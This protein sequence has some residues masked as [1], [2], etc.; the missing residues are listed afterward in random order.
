VLALGDKDNIVRF[1]KSKESP[2]G[3]VALVGIET[4]NSRMENVDISGGSGGYHDG[5]YFTGMFS[6]YDTDNIRLSNI[7]ISNNYKYD[8]LI[9]VLYSNKVDFT[10]CIV[11]NAVSDALDV[12]I[13]SVTINNCNFI[14]SGNDSIDSMTSTVKISETN[15]KNSGDKGVSAGERSHVFISKV[16]INESEIAI[17]SKDDSLVEVTNSSFLNNKVQLNAYRKNWRYGGGGRINVENSSFSGVDN[18]IT[19]KG[20]SK[21]NIVN[22]E[23]NQKYLH[24]KNKKVT[25]IN[26]RLTTE[27]F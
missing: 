17:Q 1:V 25:F 10:D 9:H 23:F 21:I 12:D 24:M 13:S 6:I 26:N 27:K 8:D 2:W 19:A 14:N 18:V 7:H 16:N 22:S 20:K 11:S 5:L 15:I 4:R 3:V